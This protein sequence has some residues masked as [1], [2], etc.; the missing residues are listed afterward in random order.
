VVWGGR[1]CRSS[2]TRL[3]PS[4]GQIRLGTCLH[5]TVH[6]RVSSVGTVWVQHCLSELCR[7]RKTISVVPHAGYSKTVIPPFETRMQLEES[8]SRSNNFGDLLPLG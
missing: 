5:S 1:R 4:I 2:L 8:I 6:A 3:T 7:A